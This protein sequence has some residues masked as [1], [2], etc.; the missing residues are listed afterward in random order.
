MAP[1]RLFFFLQEY[2]GSASFMLYFVFFEG[3][4]FVC[5]IWCSEPLHRGK[6]FIFGFAFLASTSGWHEE[7]IIKR[8]NL[9]RNITKRE[10]LIRTI[11]TYIF[12]EKVQWSYVMAV[13]KWLKLLRWQV[14]TDNIS[15]ST[16]PDVAALFN[17][18][19]NGKLINV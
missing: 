10:M 15:R 6:L 7:W 11:T 5:W 1:P 9:K 3:I 4:Y 12:I 17:V 19:V 16:R 8:S 13:G 2:S 18:R 14:R